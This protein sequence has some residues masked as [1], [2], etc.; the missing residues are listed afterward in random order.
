MIQPPH[1][2]SLQKSQKNKDNL[3]KHTNTHLILP[4]TC[5]HSKNLYQPQHYNL[6]LMGVQ[7]ETNYGV[8]KFPKLSSNDPMLFLLNQYTR[9][10][11]TIEKGDMIKHPKSRVQIQ[12]IDRCTK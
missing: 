9:C 11:P 6:T 8:R 1:I 12:A 3:P 7:T 2:V 5:Q 4:H 10:T